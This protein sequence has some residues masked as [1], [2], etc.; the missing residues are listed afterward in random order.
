MARNQPS[1]RTMYTVSCS[2][3]TKVSLDARG[4]GKPTVCKKCGVLFIVGWG[5]DR[6][7][8][9]APV[10]ATVAR[11]MAAR[12]LT[13]V[14][15]CGYRRPVTAQEAAKNSRCPG[16]GKSMIVEKSKSAAPSR[17]SEKIIKLPSRPPVLTPPEMKRIDLATRAPGG[18][19]PEMKRIDLHA[20]PSSYSKGG[21]TCDCGQTLEIV[22]ALEG[23]EYT[24][25]ACGRAVKMEKAHNPHTGHT[26]IRPRF[27]PAGL[28]PTPPP[29]LLPKPPEPEPVVEF[30][31]D[32]EPRI[33]PQSSSVQE[34]F[35][36][37]GEALMVGSD[38]VGKNIQCPTC[39][40]LM[41][42]DLSRD[43]NTGAAGLRVKAIG[44][45]DQDTWSLSDFS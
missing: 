20:S 2:C 30:A 17:D 13:L 27:G 1:A 19:P 8:K 10:L 42:V 12:P 18:T 29:G 43:P 14:C 34:L 33:A 24:C 40:T 35:C 6:A 36:P 32:E 7:G 16:C 23:K 22:R 28:P 45:M 37:C 3:S 9:A 26:V 44:K 25:P 39:L 41:S 38:D 11:K 31:E 4:F 15:S 21:L 5:K